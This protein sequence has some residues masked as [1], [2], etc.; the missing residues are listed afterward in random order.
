MQSGFSSITKTIKGK[1]GI[2]V[3]KKRKRAGGE[4][5]NKG[6]GTQRAREERNGES[7]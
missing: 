1:N 2:D 6:R 3:S 7:P 5:T 4:E